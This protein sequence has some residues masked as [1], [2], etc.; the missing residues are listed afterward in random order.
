VIPIFIIV[1]LNGSE[2]YIRS[3]DVKGEIIART[4]P[5]EMVSD[6]RWWATF[7]DKLP[8]QHTNTYAEITNRPSRWLCGI[9]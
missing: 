3:L 1:G 5:V 2:L 9:S 8:K 6:M 4:D 7:D